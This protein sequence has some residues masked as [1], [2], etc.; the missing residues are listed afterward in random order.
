MKILYHV[1]FWKNVVMCNSSY[2]MI[3]P[4][5]DFFSVLAIP[6]NTCTVSQSMHWNE[7]V[8]R[9]VWK[10][11]SDYTEQTF[12]QAERD[13]RRAERREA[14]NRGGKQHYLWC[15]LQSTLVRSWCFCECV[16]VNATCWGSTGSAQKLFITWMKVRAEE[17]GRQ[18]DKDR[19]FK[20]TWREE[21][22][23]RNRW[24]RR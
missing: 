2:S 21:K 6:F 22:E 23:G 5:T 1:V 17:G 14:E 8:W 3:N 7:V 10:C 16:C 13:D 15:Y 12:T 11:V 9:A 20:S 24:E 4:L 19:V 18:L